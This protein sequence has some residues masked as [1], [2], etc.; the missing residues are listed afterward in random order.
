MDRYIFPAVFE[1]DGNGGYT[2]TFPDLPGCITEGDTLDEALYM[3]KDALELYI[4]NLEE[5]NE[6]IPAPTAPEKIKVPEGAFV[7]LIEVYMPPV[8]EEMANKSV[9]KTVTIPRWLNEAAEKANINFSQVLQYALKEQL[10]ITDRY[11]AL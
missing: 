2:V 1:S 11:K 7:N 8:R 3:A 4:Y 5:D 9:N 10:K 6:T